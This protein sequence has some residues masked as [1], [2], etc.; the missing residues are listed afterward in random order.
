[1]KRSA[2]MPLP[3]VSSRSASGLAAWT[4]SRVFPALI[5]AAMRSRTVAI[6]SRNALRAALSPS[7]PWPGITLVSGPIRAST[8]SSAAIMPL[9][10]PPVEMSIT[11]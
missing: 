7:G 9:I 10:E 8:R 6:M 2:F 1:M 4:C 3:H 11:G 5:W